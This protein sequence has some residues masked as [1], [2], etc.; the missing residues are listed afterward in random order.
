MTRD[1]TII[2]QHFHV[3]F[4]GF[5]EL[6]SVMRGTFVASAIC[7]LAKHTALCNFF[8][9]ERS[10]KDQ[11]TFFVSSTV[12]FEKKEQKPQVTMIQKHRQTKEAYRTVLVFTL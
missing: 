4:S 11:H 7:K 2:S 5:L 12:L 6:L 9:A 1:P 3:G 10:N 8:S